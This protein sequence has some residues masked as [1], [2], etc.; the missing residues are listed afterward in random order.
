MMDFL[1]VTR[2]ETVT[3]WS[4]AVVGAFTDLTDWRCRVTMARVFDGSAVPVSGRCRLPMSGSTQQQLQRKSG[5][6]G[7]IFREGGRVDRSAI[8]V[9]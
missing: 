6:D 9:R 7:V 2:Y 5:T 4:P 1:I 8:A 3:A